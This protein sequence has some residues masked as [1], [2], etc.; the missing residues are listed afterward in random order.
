MKKFKHLLLISAFWCGAKAAFAQ[1]WTQTSAPQTNWTSVASSADGAKL[2]AA[3]SNGGI[4]V[5]TNSG[6]TWM[7]TSAPKT[8]WASIASSADGGKLVAGASHITGGGTSGFL[9]ISTDSGNTWITNNLPNEGWQSVAS[10][11]DGSK[12]VTLS[13]PGLGGKDVIFASTD[14]G[15]TWV[16]TNVNIMNSVASSADGTKLVAVGLGTY[17][18]TNSGTSWMQTNSLAYGVY[19]LASSANGN[20]LVAGGAWIFVSTNSGMTWTQMSAPETN[21]N[22]VASSADGSRL[23]AVAGGSRNLQNP[24]VNGPVY[25]STNLGMTWTS[26]CVPVQDWNSVASSADGNKLMAVVYGGGIWTLQTTPSPQLNLTLSDTKLALAWI[27]PSMNFVLQQSADLSSWSVVTNQPVLNL[28]NLQ[29]EVILPPPDSNV[30][31]RLKT[32]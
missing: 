13:G 26:N 31:Y 11:A 19:S 12:L 7:Q 30:F 2:A 21:W 3:A 22:T 23:V 14:S 20:C 5:S 29:N 4:W 28:T 16:T 1:T 18:S 17:I 15:N 10:S 25:T 27:I 32:P 8:F 24:V 6:N 9:Y